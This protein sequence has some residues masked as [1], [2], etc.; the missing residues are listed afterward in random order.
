MIA[1]F[2]QLACL[3]TMKGRRKIDKVERQPRKL[4]ANVACDQNPCSRS[5]TTFHLLSPNSIM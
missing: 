3:G 2:P 5:L 4:G 1:P